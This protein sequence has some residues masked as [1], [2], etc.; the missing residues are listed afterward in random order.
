[1]IQ[2]KLQGNEIVLLARTLAPSLGKKERSIARF[3]ENNPDTLSTMC[4]SDMSRFLK[5]S[6]SSI[7]K[8][9]KKLGFSGFH[10]LKNNIGIEL[11]SEEDD[12]HSFSGS[13]DNNGRLLEESF[14]SAI[15]A[16]QDSL[17][18]VNR[19]VFN[20]VAEIL[21]NLNGDNKLILAGC[22]GSGAICDDFHHKLLKIG[23]FSNVYHDAHL[24][25]MAASLMKPGDIL[26]GVSHSGKTS[27]IIN[28][29]KT[30]QENHAHTICLTNYLN[31]PLSH[32][33]D[34]AMV[35]GVR[36]N[37][38]TGENASTRIVHLT[39]LDALFTV[40]ASKRSSVS[41]TSLQKTRNSVLSKRVKN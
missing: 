23:M 20:Q 15:L 26:L 14:L 39:I 36:N 35:S 32:L 18:T 40:V 19:E 16:L 13:E 2:Q 9:S 30:A 12:F 34:F 33:A 5:V 29:I 11:N 10:E 37:P 8:V 25:Q 41:Q 27:D 21:A 22:G 6:V 28:M 7:T 24:Q 4:I 1:M 38:I 3:I 31:S 17:S